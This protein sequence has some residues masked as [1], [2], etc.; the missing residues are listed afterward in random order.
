MKTILL[1]SLI[2]STQLAFGKV[3]ICK[4]KIVPV[5]TEYTNNAGSTVVT[6][7]AERDIKDFAVEEVRGIDG[8]SVT[9][10]VSISPR[11]LKKDEKVSLTINYSKPDGQVFLVTDISA[12]VN[13]QT[14]YQTLA[15]PVGEL[16][17]EQMSARKKN[18][19]SLP[20]VKKNK[21]GADA[22]ESG[23]KYHTMKLP[24]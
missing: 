7:T 18:I 2:F 6:Y 12:S 14:K 24:E 4:Q 9:K 20:G 23:E 22:L 1:L 10:K 15:I 5:K 17:S 11:D 16:S 21:A 19:K 3:L 8:L 13:E